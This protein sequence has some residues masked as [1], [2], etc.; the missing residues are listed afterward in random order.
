MSHLR[1][2]GSEPPKRPRKTRTPFS[3]MLLSHDERIRGA[4][5]LR[6]LKSAFGT[7]DCL[8]DA[9]GV[10][11]KML[12]TAIRLGRVTVNILYAASRA[13]GLTIDDLLSAP[14][15]TDRCRACGQVK[16]YA[17]ALEARAV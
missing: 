1:I 15:P 9:M 10:D 16:R 4:Q 11:T 17:K 2:V 14:V 7:W 13:S 3:S 5:A 8:S 6:N 12:H